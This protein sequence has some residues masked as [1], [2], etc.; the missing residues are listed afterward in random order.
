[1]NARREI[2]IAEKLRLNRTGILEWI[3]LW[4]ILEQEW[5][6][7][8]ISRC[9]IMS[10]TWLKFF[11]LE[12][13]WL[14][15]IGF[16]VIFSFFYLFSEVL[17]V[18][19]MLLDYRECTRVFC[20]VCVSILDS[21]GVDSTEV[22]WSSGHQINTHSKAKTFPLLSFILFISFFLFSSSFTYL[23]FIN[24]MIYLTSFHL[25]GSNCHL[26]LHIR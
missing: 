4:D 14:N 25:K 8:C 10:K 2:G 24:T 7:P 5:Q 15:C 12:I 22:V 3:F 17:L 21:T 13:F 23:S 11:G 6:F 26:R 16:S 19:L 9:E 18:D 20:W 1:M